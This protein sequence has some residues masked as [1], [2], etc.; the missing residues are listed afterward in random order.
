[1][2]DL[3]MYALTYPVVLEGPVTVKV[4]SLLVELNS[5]SVRDELD[6]T[7]NTSWA[8]WVKKGITVR[9]TVVLVLE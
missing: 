7:E 9:L 5:R 6:T 8:F 1:M 4:S 2:R 3:A